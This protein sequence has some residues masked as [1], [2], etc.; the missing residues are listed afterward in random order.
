MNK[1][2][3]IERIRENSTIKEAAPIQDSKVYGP[4]EQTPCD[5]AMINVALSGGVDGGLSP[6]SLILAG[7]SKHFK[8]S[9]ALMMAAAFQKKHEDAILLF[10]DSE[11]GSPP[12]YFES[13]DIDMDRVFHTPITN[14]E[15]LKFDLSKQIVSF[16]KED[17][18]II[19]VDSFGNLASKKEAQDAL[20]GN[21]KADMTRAKELKSLFRII[22]PLLNMKAIPLIGIGHTY[23]TM[24]L[25]PKDV[26]SGGTGIMYSADDAWIIGRQQE[27]TG[28]EIVGYNFI[29]NIEKSRSVR[30]KSK[31]PIGVTFEGGIK[32]WS[33]LLDVALDL[34]YARS[35]KKGWYELIDP[36]SGEV[37]S[38]KAYRAKT[39]D[40]SGDVWKYMFENTSF[41]SAIKS[42]FK[43]GKGEETSSDTT[44]IE[45]DT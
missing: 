22:T 39:L 9:F 34:G 36:D 13:F 44:P 10:Y 28:T 6:G 7:P 24:D 21:S 29:I 3:L 43:F 45:N 32:K 8:T 26:I 19:V 1:K 27:K 17:N 37:I 30:E 41:K 42:R 15:E 16:T 33:G 14:I 11:F 35:S 20:D 4:K 18:V 5:V 38:G 23:K 2:S 12:E 31:I 25:F 40:E